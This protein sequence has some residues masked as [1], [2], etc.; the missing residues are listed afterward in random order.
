MAF[1]PPQI[2]GLPSFA[3]DPVSPSIGYIWFN[4]TTQ[5]PKIQTATGPVVLAGNVTNLIGLPV[6]ASDP[7]S[8]SI[9]QAWYNS[10]SNLAKINLPSGVQ[11]F[12]TSVPIPPAPVVDAFIQKTG[13]TSSISG[14]LGNSAAGNLVIVFVMLAIDSDFS[15]LTVGGINATRLTQNIVR[16]D[17]G[18]VAVNCELDIY[19]AA[20][21]GANASVVLTQGGLQPIAFIAAAFSGSSSQT[22]EDS[23]SAA[24]HYIHTDT[25]LTETVNIALGTA[26]RTP[27]FCGFLAWNQ[28]N[29]LA[30]SGTVTVIAEVDGNMSSAVGNLF[31]M[32]M[33][34]AT[35]G[36]AHSYFDQHNPQQVGS[37]DFG[38][39]MAGVTCVDP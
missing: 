4:T 20:G 13:S 7:V 19:V 34:T 35:D 11:Q 5:Q 10:T 1:I 24:A 3:V 33:G 37:L 8:P 12:N 38:C 2:T 36:A 21:V 28:T 18:A 39:L 29:N 6:V 27:V 16:Y 30:V 15:S 23:A 26:G 14:S 31:R 9:G 17:N 22:T 32:I 25:T